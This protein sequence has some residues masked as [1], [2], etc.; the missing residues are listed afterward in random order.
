[1]RKPIQVRIT[2]QNQ[3]TVIVLSLRDTSGRV[4]KLFRNYSLEVTV[5]YVVQFYWNIMA[6]EI[7]DDVKDLTVVFK[8]YMLSLDI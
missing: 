5:E 6:E 7:A 3:Q 2:R 8:T 1:M 4:C